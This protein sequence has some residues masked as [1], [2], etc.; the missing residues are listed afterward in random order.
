MH[1]K[2]WISKMLSENLKNL[3]KNRGL[4]Q[5]QLS[6]RLN[7]TRQTISKWEKGL[8]VPDAELLLRIAEVLNVSV[9]DLMEE[10]IVPEQAVPSLDTIAAELQKQNDLLAAQQARRSVIQKKILTVVAILLLLLFAG[11]IYDKWNAIFYDFGQ[12]IYH[13]LH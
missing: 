1:W 12:N 8:S 10:T 4:S 13:W 3:R 2:D 11:A 6:T 7:V 9:S 5:Q